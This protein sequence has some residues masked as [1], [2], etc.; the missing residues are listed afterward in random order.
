MISGGVMPAWRSSC[1]SSP[2]PPSICTKNV[3]TSTQL[4]KCGRYTTVCTKLRR[5]RDSTLFSVRASAIGSGK[6]KTSWNAVMDSVFH[7]A[8]QK[9]GSANSTSKLPKPTHGLASSAC[10]GLSPR[11][12]L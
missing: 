8:S 11:Y 7:T 5:R 3:T 4:K 2:A 6:K 9:A 1:D 12:G 10:S